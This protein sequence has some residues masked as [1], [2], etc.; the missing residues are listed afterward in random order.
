MVKAK[1]VEHYETHIFIA[2]YKNGQKIITFG[3]VKIEKRSF[4][5]RKDPVCLKDV[6]NDKTLLSKSFFYFIIGSKYDCKIR[7]LQLILPKIRGRAKNFG[8]YIR[9]SFLTEDDKL[10]QKYNKIWD[11]VCDSIK[12][13][14]RTEPVESEKHL[15]TKIKS[16]KR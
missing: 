10:L 8:G 16:C 1:K 13:E 9:M 7:L 4:H 14:F 2:S 3:K 12:E 6:D 11:N 5:Y 15:R